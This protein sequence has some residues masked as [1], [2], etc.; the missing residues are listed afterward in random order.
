MYAFAL[1]LSVPVLIVTIVMSVLTATELVKLTGEPNGIQKNGTNV[2]QF[3]A[4]T[5]ANYAG[6]HDVL[7]QGMAAFSA[8][9][10]DVVTIGIAKDRTNY[11]SNLGCQY[12]LAQVC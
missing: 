12:A 6:N 2:L 11:T 9:A 7:T 1:D 3:D 4:P 10:G 8:S 5:V